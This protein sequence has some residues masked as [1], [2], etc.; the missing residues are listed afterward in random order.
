MVGSAIPRTVKGAL[1]ENL[2]GEIIRGD[3]IPG[4]YLRLDE[5]ADRYD[6]STMPVREALRDLEAEG[7]VTIYPHRGAVVSELSAEDLEDIYEIRAVL[8][9]MAARLA[10]PRL[11][12]AVLAEIDRLVEQMDGQLG[13]VVALV[14]L[15][16]QLHSTIYGASGRRHL[17]ELI[18]TLRYR[19]QHYLRAYVADQGEMAMAQEE[20]RAMLEGC[21]LGD[22]ERVAAIVE[23]HVAQVGRSLI[24]HFYNQ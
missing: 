17:E 10:V 9:G 13:D 11:T 19:T 18:Q 22:A 5:I 12:P 15:N 21:K 7:L 8:E 23:E 3:L 6:V 16:H 1:V 24:D 2:R 20:H 4:Q 14:R